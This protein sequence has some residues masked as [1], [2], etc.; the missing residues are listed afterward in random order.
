MS[1]GDQLPA[2]STVVLW[3]CGIP[4][5]LLSFKNT[6]SIAESMRETCLFLYAHRQV[7]GTTNH[8]CWG[9]LPLACA[10]SCTAGRRIQ[11][12]AML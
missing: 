11:L 10:A 3:V 1:Y 7:E 12:Q 6:P 8:I 4:T 2:C 5:T 9:V